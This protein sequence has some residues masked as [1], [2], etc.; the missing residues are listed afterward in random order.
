MK[1]PVAL[2]IMIHHYRN[3]A[4]FPYLSGWTVELS[5][6]NAGMHVES[7][8]I[9]TQLLR[10]PTLYNVRDEDTSALPTCTTKFLPIYLLLQTL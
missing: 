9:D 2:N 8:L 7:Y 4:Y 6:G 1:L 5:I 10:I 3:M